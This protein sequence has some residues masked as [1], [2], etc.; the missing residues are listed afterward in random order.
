MTW[1]GLTVTGRCVMHMIGRSASET[2][3]FTTGA[4][5]RA[6]VDTFDPAARVWHRHYQDGLDVVIVVPAGTELIPIPFPLGH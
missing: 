1:N 5:R 4:N 3:E 6:S 2:C